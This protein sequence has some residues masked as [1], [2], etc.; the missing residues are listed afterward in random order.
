M[1]VCDNYK[2][3]LCWLLCHHINTAHNQPTTHT[4]RSSSR[5]WQTVVVTLRSP[6]T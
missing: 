5:K 2:L 6:H 3:P 4:W 1:T